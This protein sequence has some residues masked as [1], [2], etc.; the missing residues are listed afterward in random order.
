M[1]YSE[2]SHFKRKFINILSHFKQRGFYLMRDVRAIL[3]FVSITVGPLKNQMQHLERTKSAPPIPEPFT[4]LN[5][6]TVREV[7]NFVTPG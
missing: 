6:Y 5:L 7:V 4:W 1:S 2:A 3:M